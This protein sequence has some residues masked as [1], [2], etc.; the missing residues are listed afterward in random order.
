MQREKRSESES[1]ERK[2]E[3]VQESR[4]QDSGT[5]SAVDGAL[6]VANQAGE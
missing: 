5:E 1:Q 3:V 6:E 2:D 4:V